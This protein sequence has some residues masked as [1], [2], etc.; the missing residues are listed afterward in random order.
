[1]DGGPGGGE[2]V[3]NDA[4]PTRGRGRTAGRVGLAVGA[5][6][7]LL[8]VV[9]LARESGGPSDPRTDA[10][11]GSTTPTDVPTTT[12][13]PPTTT[14]TVPPPWAEF[15]IDEPAA[16]E[17][18][19]SDWNAAS[20]ADPANVQRVEDPTRLVAALVRAGEAHDAT[21]ALQDVVLDQPGEYVI[22]A[23]LEVP[24]G[25]RLRGRV[26]APG[27]ADQVV[28]AA[29]DFPAD[30]AMV[31]LASDTALSQI[32]IDGRDVAWRIVSAA[33]AT[34]VTIAG[35]HLHSTNS[36]VGAVQP[37]FNVSGSR[38]HTDLILLDQGTERVLI[39]G[40]R[41]E[42]AGI[43]PTDG[44]GAAPTEWSAFSTAVSTD[45]AS[46]VTITRTRI[47]ETATAGISVWRAQRI[48]ITDNVIENVG[49]NVE[50]WAKGGPIALGDGITG[51]N[52]AS[53]TRRARRAAL[54][55]RR[56]PDPQQR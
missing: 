29:P 39:D 23:P 24:S 27:F 3:P 32:Q 30:E 10:V 8:A 15:G 18:S 33:G 2:P 44:R 12:T 26:S 49:R 40:A 53:E 50:W 28:A 46:D 56:E 55:H 14:T 20:Q 7:L 31:V 25:V 5:V 37:P 45:M 21:G 48:A 9:T 16:P 47:S 11:S 38:P 42:F 19:L 51:Y 36:R 17:H 1:M 6:L 52:H 41:L 13:E 4:E 35:S 54:D 34:D 43:N 22:S